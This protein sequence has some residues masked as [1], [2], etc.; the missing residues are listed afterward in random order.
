MIKNNRIMDL[1]TT[2]VL[3][4]VFTTSFSSDIDYKGQAHARLQLIC[5][6]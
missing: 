1:K 3:G 6:P 4:A 2:K 5:Q